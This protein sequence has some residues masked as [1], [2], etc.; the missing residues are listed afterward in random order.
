MDL[1][2]NE[3]SFR[4]NFPDVHASKKGM[5][6][7][8]R[9]CKRAAELGISKLAVRRD[10][11]EQFLTTKYSILDWLA[12]PTVSRTYKD[13][14]QSIRRFPYIDERD[15]AVEDRFILSGAFLTDNDEIAVEGLAVTYLYN[16]ISASLYTAEK[17]NVNQIDLKFSEGDE[18]NHIVSVKHASQV[19]HVEGHKEWIANR[20]GVKIHATDL[21]FSRK[22]IELRDDHGKNVL[23][24]FSQKLVRSPWL[25]GV[26]NSLPFN[27]RDRNFIKN[28][29]A[30]GR[31]EIVLVRS[32]QGLGLVV[33]STGTNLA[34]TEAIAK[35][36]RE[37][38]EDQ[39]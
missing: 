14:F 25:L 35:I 39:Y 13:L 28:V 37:E 26:I 1:I 32:D 38:F 29:Y 18:P 19:V 22:A 20:I 15:T 12:D 2:F 21:P 5:E 31:I 23:Y 16:S 24:K 10:F 7:L 30:D 34:E 4:D 36:L 3:C 6:N 9:V 17:W 27:P 8:L 11:Y 33:Q